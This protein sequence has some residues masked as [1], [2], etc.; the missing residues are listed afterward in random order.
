M[1]SSTKFTTCIFGVIINEVE[2]LSFILL[3]PK[4]C[5]NCDESHERGKPTAIFSKRRKIDAFCANVL[6]MGTSVDLREYKS[7]HL[8]VVMSVVD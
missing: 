6:L 5:K 7:S 8:L 3:G 4:P 1:N 2:I